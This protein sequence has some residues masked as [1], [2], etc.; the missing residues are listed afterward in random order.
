MASRHDT[1]QAGAARPRRTRGVPSMTERQ[2]QAYLL[3]RETLRGIQ[4]AVLA[5][6]GSAAPALA[7]R[8]RP[9]PDGMSAR[10]G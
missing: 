4:G 9:P 7:A 10:D 8:L 5:R 2:L 6:D 1:S 3:A